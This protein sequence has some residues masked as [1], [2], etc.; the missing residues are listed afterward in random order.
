MK[1]YSVSYV[2]R[3]EQDLT[4]IADYIKRDSPKNSA[5]WLETVD[6]ILGRL[7]FF[8]YSGVIPKDKYLASLGYRIVVL[9]EYLVFYCVRGRKVEIRRVLH[10]R[11]RYGFLL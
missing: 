11:R 2:R 6:K 8:P 9:G 5:V 3:A 4:E 1:R 7:A 10:G